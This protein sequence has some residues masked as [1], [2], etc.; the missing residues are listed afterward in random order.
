MGNHTAFFLQAFKPK[1]LI[2]VDADPANLPFIRRTV[3]NNTVTKPQLTLINAFVG[4]GGPP[5][6]FAGVSVAQQTL[7]DLGANTAELI[8]IDVDGAEMQVLSHA[9]VAMLDHKPLIM[10]ETTPRTRTDVDSWFRARAF[11]PVRTF[12][13]GGYANTIWRAA[14]DVN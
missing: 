12:D 5:T 6:S 14:H 2:L 8:K 1:R 10:I 7:I 11:E 3:K 9:P 13:H 4:G